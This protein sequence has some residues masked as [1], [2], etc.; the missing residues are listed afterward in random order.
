MGK[1]KKE[2][3][4]S[5]PEGMK[6]SNDIKNKSVRRKRIGKELLEKRKVINTNLFDSSL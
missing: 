2:A 4:D 1:I 6:K 5:I 3:E